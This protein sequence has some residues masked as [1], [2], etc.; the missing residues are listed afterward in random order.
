[1]VNNIFIK[2]ITSLIVLIAILI[3]IYIFSIWQ[4]QANQY[5]IKKDIITISEKAYIWYNT[6]DVTL[7]EKIPFNELTFNKINFDSTNINA[8]YEIKGI[9]ENKIEIIA[10]NKKNNIKIVAIIDKNGKIKFH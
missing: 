7:R 3:G 5:A 9:D 10:I 4:K 6:K 1:M 2:I 8:N